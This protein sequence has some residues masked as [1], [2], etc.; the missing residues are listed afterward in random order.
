MNQFL[1]SLF[2]GY[3]KT[4]NTLTNHWG[5]KLMKIPLFSKTIRINM[6]PLIYVNVYEHGEH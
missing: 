2:N 1:F 3:Q 4:Y 6:V 5:Y